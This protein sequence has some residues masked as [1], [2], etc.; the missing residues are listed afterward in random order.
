MNAL[1]PELLVSN[2]D[3]SLAFWIGL[4]GFEIVF[5]RPAERFAFLR[6]D[7][8]EVMIEQVGAGR[9]WL[10]GDLEKP[11]GRGINLQ[12]L[13]ADWTWALARLRRHEWP[14]FMEP[15][16][17]WYQT[18]AEDVG[19]TQFLVQDPDGYLL[20]LAQPLAPRLSQ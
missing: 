11:L 15:E 9:N 19:Q 4:L 2:I 16:E 10:S 13:A 12:M 5:D 14:L 17:K 8:I 3:T 6:L 7:A 18:G 20:R 1:V